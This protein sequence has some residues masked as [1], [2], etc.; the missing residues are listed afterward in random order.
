MHVRS[1]DVSALET[2]TAVSFFIPGTRT[3][4]NEIAPHEAGRYMRRW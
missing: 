2:A 4:H 1:P 3:L